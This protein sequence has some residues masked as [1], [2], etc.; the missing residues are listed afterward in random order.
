MLPQGVGEGILQIMS[1]V[2]K[3]IAYP[4][5]CEIELEPDDRQEDYQKFR[6]LFKVLFQNISLIR[7]VREGFLQMLG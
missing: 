3:R 2:L 6:E 7:P 5:W 4:E 1:V